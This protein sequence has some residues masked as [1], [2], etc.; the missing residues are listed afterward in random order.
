MQAR[1]TSDLETP[2]LAVLRER[3]RRDGPMP[4]DEYMRQCLAHPEH[5]YWRRGSTIGAEGDF[6]TAPEISQIFGELLGLWCAVVWQAIGS[7]APVH[8]VELG[9]GRGTLM[10]DA[11]RAAKLVPRFLQSTIIDLVEIN[12]PLR[13]RQKDT[14]ASSDVP[15]TLSK[16]WH[17]SLKEIPD[18]PSIILANEFLDALPIRQLIWVGRSWRERVVE[19]GP[20][21][22][23]HFA[24]GPPVRHDCN[25][26][27]REGAIVELRP[28]ENDLIA[29]IARRRGPQIALFIDYGHFESSHADTLQ[30]VRQHRYTDPLEA[31]GLSDLTA[32]VDFASLSRKARAERLAVD[33]PI[34]QADFLGKLG[35]AER[36]A[37]LMALN[38]NRAGEIEAGA[39]RLMS[40]TGMG[41][42]FKVL[43]LRTPEL[44]SL[45]PF[46]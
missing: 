42:L 25:E 38:P 1:E 22:N 6:I 40:P 20:A 34:T 28:G 41:Q 37:R 4:V 27:A 29:H 24:V 10:R 36:A 44:P 43:A 39:Q 30:A 12:E 14:L 13:Q 2:L 5:G 35:I 46:G 26:P 32:H 11:L 9:P 7:P 15:D 21:G 3:I 19:L 31:P 23:L 8:I 17:S 16:V 33:G 18:G 45:P